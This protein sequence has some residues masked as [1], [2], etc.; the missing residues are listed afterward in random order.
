MGMRG[1]W[2]HM[3]RGLGWPTIFIHMHGC[4]EPRDH[5]SKPSTHDDT[6]SHSH[7]GLGS[8]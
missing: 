7:V 1:I 3:L 6:N 4:N 2:L 5:M 8:F